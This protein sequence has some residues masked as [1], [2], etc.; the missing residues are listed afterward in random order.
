MNLKRLL[1]ESKLVVALV[2]LIFAR[3]VDRVLYT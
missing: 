1:W 2:A 3:C